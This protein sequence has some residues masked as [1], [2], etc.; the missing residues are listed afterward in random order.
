MGSPTGHSLIP[1]RDELLK[2]DRRAGV[3]SCVRV[4]ILPLDKESDVRCGSV[5]PERALS[6]FQ[7]A[8]I[9]SIELKDLN[10]TTT[11]RTPG[12]NSDGPIA[13]SNR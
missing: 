1:S 2:A 8:L 6:G 12:Q 4:L 9:G 3:H 5:K 10:A 13:I 7:R 11:R